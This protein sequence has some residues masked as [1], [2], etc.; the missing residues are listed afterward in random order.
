VSAGPPAKLHD[1]LHDTGR[2]WLAYVVKILVHAQVG[3]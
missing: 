3:R 2:A 1:D